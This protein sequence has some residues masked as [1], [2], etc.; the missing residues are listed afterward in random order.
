MVTQQAES[1]SQMQAFETRAVSTESHGVIC[2]LV[3][4]L[5]IKYKA[6]YH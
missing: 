2:L 1:L 3:S 6:G 4:S 5:R